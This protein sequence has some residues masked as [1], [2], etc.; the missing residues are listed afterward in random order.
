MSSDSSLR[1][2]G[3]HVISETLDGEAVVINLETGVYYSLAGTASEIW[4][5]VQQG[6][7]RSRVVSELDRRYRAEPGEI[8]SAVDQLLGKMEDEKLLVREP[9]GSSG[10]STQPA[11]RAPEGAPS[12]RP[13]VEPSIERFTDI[14][15]LLLLDPIHEVDDRGWPHE[16]SE[17]KA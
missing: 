12:D 16:P 14:Q 6:S 4:D 8:A 17:Q 15:D 2:P 9:A 3:A 13:F 1:V 10:T 7:R 5:H 11:E